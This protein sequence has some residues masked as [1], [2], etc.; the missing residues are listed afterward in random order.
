MGIARPERV[1]LPSGTVKPEASSRFALLSLLLAA[2]LLLHQLWWGGFEVRSLHFVVVVAALWVM[3]R[4]GSV[5]R[6]VAMLGAEVVS[7]AREMPAVHSHTLLVLVCAVSVLAFV[8]LGAA[9]SRRL[10]D[11]GGLFERIAPFLRASVLV[12]YASAGIAKLN[13][14]FLDP[15]TSCAAGMAAQVAWFDPSLLAGAGWIATPAI[16]G[17]LAVELS[18]PV[19]LAVPR[20]RVAG[21]ALG[22]A[23]H[24][25]LALAG[26]VPFSSLM[27]A[28]YV[29][30]L[31]AGVAPRALARWRAP[32]VALPLAVG[33][34][35]AAAV[36]LDG[37]PELG[38]TLI[39]QGT[40]LAAVALIAFVAVRMLRARPL[41]ATGGLRL[42]HPV[43]VAGM[44]V[45]LLN[46][47][48]PYVG[49]KTESSFAMFS[50]L[51]TEPGR[52]N[53]VFVPE[54][55]RVLGF[56]E[57]LVAVEATNDPALVRRTRGGKR[58]VRYELERY[59]RLRPASRAIYDGGP[60]R[61]SAATPLLD[62]VAK[63][64]DVR[65][66]DRPGC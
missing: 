66:V 54:A 61:T 15:V 33:A 25:V 42:G 55:V 44:A 43:F 35:V 7:V 6:F 57:E 63:F 45:L 52:W 65:P 21:L 41:R 20:W 26:N 11:P 19:L 28:L 32:K 30:F 24:A 31:P 58:L 16:S 48:S 29:A 37:R 34:W 10:P 2:A 39:E 59:L 36:L 38:R 60:A 53:H 4:P 64:R 49:F 47:M 22:L 8:A 18:L 56:Q 23:F 62:R 12:L 14:G 51:Q 13:S 3:A 27:L 40:R 17:T 1:G 9:R 50:N 5:G 46:A